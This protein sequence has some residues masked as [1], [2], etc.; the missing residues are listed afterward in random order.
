M[1]KKTDKPAADPKPSMTEEVKA[2]A[3]PAEETWKSHWSVSRRLLELRRNLRGTK[4]WKTFEMQRAFEAFSIHALADEIEAL[5]CDC[6]LISSFRI[7]K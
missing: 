4:L 1:I 7:T 5:A 6:G 2:A 3:A